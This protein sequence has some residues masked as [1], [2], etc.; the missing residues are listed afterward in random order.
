M[1]RKSNPF[2]LSPVEFRGL[3]VPF[4]NQ[5]ILLRSFV[6]GTQA[7]VCEEGEFPMAD[8]DSAPLSAEEREELEALREE[9]ARREREERDRRDR[10][11]LAALRAEQKRVDDEILAERAASSS[12][13]P[14]ARQAR[15]GAAS[16]ST[17]RAHRTAANELTLG[18]KMVMT[19]AAKDKDDVPG[20]APA[21]KII[22][23][24]ALIFVVLGVIYMINR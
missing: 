11:E 17:S 1:L 10:A 21:Q 7:V 22:I 24:V 2:H 6:Y 4:S 18:Q 15:P 16:P 13:V 8:Q 12:S 19:P 14:A 20:M 23:L 3:R 5:G 9:K